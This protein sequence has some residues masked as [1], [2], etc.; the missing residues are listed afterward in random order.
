[1][2]GAKAAARSGF[3]AAV[4]V[5]AVTLGVTLYSHYVG[6]VLGFSIYNLIDVFLWSALATGL[7]FFSRIA[8]VLGFLYYIGDRVFI[9]I[10]TGEV[11][12]VLMVI[13]IGGALIQGIRGS[14]A[15]HRLKKTRE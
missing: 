2:E 9:T 4:F 13:I 5:T 7:W 15:Y 12:G 1:M 14:F 3:W 6:T 10:E 11:P 8:A